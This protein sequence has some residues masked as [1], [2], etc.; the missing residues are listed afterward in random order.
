MRQFKSVPVNVEV[1]RPI[2]LEYSN[3]DWR[4]NTPSDPHS[5]LIQ[6]LGWW[7]VAKLLVWA[8]NT[9][10]TLCQN[11]SSLFFQAT[12]NDWPYFVRSS[13]AFGASIKLAVWKNPC[14][15]LSSASSPV[16][17]VLCGVSYWTPPEANIND[18]C[19]VTLM[20]QTTLYRYIERYE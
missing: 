1:C 15:V 11:S 3:F 8:R 16:R 19:H 10:Y 4:I 9:P 17:Q 5:P 20:N 6:G 13:A 12:W 7:F 18:A 14:L 2:L